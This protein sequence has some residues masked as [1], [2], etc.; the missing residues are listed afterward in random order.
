MCPRPAL[1]PDSYGSVL[2]CLAARFP[3][4]SP[5][6]AHSSAARAHCR[7]RVFPVRDARKSFLL[8]RIWG[9]EEEGQ[10]MAICEAYITQCSM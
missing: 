4:F 8:A 10:L 3:E 6:C 1:P 5:L 7:K 2:V 9:P